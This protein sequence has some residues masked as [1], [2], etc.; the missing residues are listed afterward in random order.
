M[1]AMSREASV[2]HMEETMVTD[3]DLTHEMSMKGFTALKADE[4][5]VP[6]DTQHATNEMYINICSVG[7]QYTALVGDCCLRKLQTRAFGVSST[8]NSSLS[9]VRNAAVFSAAHKQDSMFDSHR[10]TYVLIYLTYGAL[11]HRSQVVDAYSKSTKRILL[12]DYGGTLLEKEGL[13]KY[14]KRDSISSVSGRRLNARTEAGLATLCA[15]PHN[16]VFVVSGLH[17]K[18]LLDAVGHIPRYYFY[19]IYC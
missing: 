15:D 10:L 11:P 13:G 3:G 9:V 19:S 8:A 17:P 6:T 5:C 7:K 2:T 4:V 14:L 12:F 18:G 1:W 16:T